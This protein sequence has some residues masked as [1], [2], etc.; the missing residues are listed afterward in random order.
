MAALVEGMTDTSGLVEKQHSV[1]V[2]KKSR[3]PIPEELEMFHGL[4][5]PKEPK[6]PEP[7]GEFF[8]Y[9]ILS[10]M[11]RGLVI[12]M[13]HVRMCGLCLRSLRRLILDIQSVAC[14]TS[15][16]VEIDGN[17]RIGVAFTHK[18]FVDFSGH[19]QAVQHKP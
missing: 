16:A 10:L 18:V 8:R 1:L 14:F 12:R 11:L 17:P 6:P 4:A 13:L 19:Q 5:I 9:F 2:H 15:D 7:D 3:V